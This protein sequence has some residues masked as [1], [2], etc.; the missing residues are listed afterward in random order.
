MDRDK[1]LSLLRENAPLLRG[2]GV[3]GLVMFGPA[4][5]N[6]IRPGGEVAFL[7]DLEPPHTF[8]HFIEIRDLLT[9]LLDHPVELVAESP[10]HPAIRPY[11]EPDAIPI[12]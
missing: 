10:H 12:V 8:A 11:I 5:R 2:R 7:L 1:M 3:K 9:G 6:E 4:A